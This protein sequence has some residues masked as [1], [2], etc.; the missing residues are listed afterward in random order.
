MYATIEGK[1]EAPPS[2]GR[3]FINASHGLKGLPN[4]LSDLAKRR[5]AKSKL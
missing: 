1:T 3:D 5:Q 4:R 2:V